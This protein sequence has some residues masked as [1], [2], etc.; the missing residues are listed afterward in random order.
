[1]EL[2]VL[3]P[4]ISEAIRKAESLEDAG[5]AGVYQAYLEVSE[6]EDMIAGLI[7]LSE[8]EGALARRG[9]LRAALVAGDLQRARELRGR[10]EAEEGVTTGFRRELA[11]V[12][13][14]ARLRQASNLAL[15]WALK[16]LKTEV[17]AA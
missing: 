17:A 16:G 6:L 14:A 1:M 10:Y 7:P 4:K 11:E 3:Y 9:A 13:E 12:W 5:D 15:D 2:D 8:P